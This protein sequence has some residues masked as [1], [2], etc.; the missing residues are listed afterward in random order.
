MT[1]LPVALT[2]ASLRWVTGVVHDPTAGIKIATL[3]RFRGCANAIRDELPEAITVLDAFYVVKLGSAMVDEVRRRVQQKTLGH[4][5]RR[6]DPLYREG[7]QCFHDEVMVS[8]HGDWETVSPAAPVVLSAAD[9]KE[10][11]LP[12]NDWCRRA[13]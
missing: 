2:S 11:S 12:K 7:P 13:A 3:D 8:L 4:R 10:A 6:G 9:P 1:I 5:G